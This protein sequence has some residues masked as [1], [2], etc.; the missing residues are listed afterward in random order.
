M[1]LLR[2]TIRVRIFGFNINGGFYQLS[3]SVDLA[4]IR[5]SD[6]EII[7][8]S[9]NWAYNDNIMK[10]PRNHISDSVRG[11][12]SSGSSNTTASGDNSN[13]ASRRMEMVSGV[14]NPCQ[15]NPRGHESVPSKM[16]GCAPLISG[17]NKKKL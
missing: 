14:M 4:R 5:L 13:Q 12:E 8:G 15:V 2:E 6:A 3:L 10:Q 17:R 1:L 7:R 16:T 9:S 11:R